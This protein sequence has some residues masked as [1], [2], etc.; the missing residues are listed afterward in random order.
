ML[1]DRAALLANRWSRRRHW[2]SVAHWAILFVLVPGLCHLLFAPGFAERSPATHA[3]TIV[4]S[5]PASDATGPGN[6]HLPATEP[7]ELFQVAGLE[8]DHQTTGLVIWQSADSLSP[9]IVPVGLVLSYLCDSARHQC[10][11]VQLI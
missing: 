4:A 3:E 1:A 2:R 10:S 5:T 6:L 9:R 8:F 11:G 7:G